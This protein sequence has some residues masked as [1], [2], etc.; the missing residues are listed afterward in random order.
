M[1]KMAMGNT[2]KLQLLGLPAWLCS[3]TQMGEQLQTS[4][5]HRLRTNP[6]YAAA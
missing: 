5:L 6:G 1:F 3:C 4:S 2:I